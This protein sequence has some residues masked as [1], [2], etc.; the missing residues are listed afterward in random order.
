MKFF[1][2]DSDFVGGNIRAT[3][4]DGVRVKLEPELRDTEGDW[5]YWAFRV[6]NAG[7]TTV[8]FDFA[9]KNWVGYFGAA[10]SHDL[11][12]WEWTRGEN[13]G[14]TS[15]FTYT[16]AEGENEVYF[17][18]DMLYHPSRFEIFAA[19]RGIELNTMLHDN[20]G[21][22]IIRVDVGQGSRAI[23]LT[24]RHHA[25]EATGDYVIEGFI[26]AYLKDPLPDTKLIV[27][28]FID[29]DGVA[30]GDQGKNRR[31]H[32]HN[33]D[34]VEGIYPAVRE[35]KRLLEAENVVAFIDCHSP[36]HLGGRNDKV[37]IV[38]KSLETLDEM[39]RFGRI[40]ESHITPESMQ[41]SSENDID[42]GEDWNTVGGKRLSASDYADGVEGVRLA[43][44]L[45]T[46]Y[47]GEVGNI[48]SQSKLVE[49][50]CCLFGAVYE[51]LFRNRL[52]HFAISHV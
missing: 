39:K 29:A 15:E 31:P 50:G 23:L 18:H 34:Y 37:F 9:P 46:T 7:G 48:V 33:R 10:V 3:G 21:T 1:S 8:T 26:D 47:F 24:A 36:W 30:N 42:P 38:R 49:L 27:L 5:F 52:E 40:L 14:S 25:C 51:Y 6:T 45:E 12:H 41:Y 32:D 4:Y 13:V 43:M 2:I 11:V 20:G 35:V 19:S 22:P 28:P 44:S 16:F 17:A